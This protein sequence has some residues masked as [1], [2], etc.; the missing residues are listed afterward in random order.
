ME[1]SIKIL[2]V[3]FLLFASHGCKANVNVDNYFDDA[4][5][6]LKDNWEMEVNGEEAQLSS[7]PFRLHSRTNTCAKII[8]LLDR[9]D[10]RS[11]E[12]VLLQS[13]INRLFAANLKGLSCA[14][15]DND[16]FIKIKNLD[17][18]N[19]PNTLTLNALAYIGG[20][21]WFLNDDS[22]VVFEDEQSK[23]CFSEDLKPKLI[24]AEVVTLEDMQSALITEDTDFFRE[25]NSMEA[26]KFVYKC[27]LS[28]EKKYYLDV[29]YSKSYYENSK[30]KHLI[31]I[32]SIE[33]YLI[34]NK[35]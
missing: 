19:F 15:L 22:K 7:P 9:I 10:K 21:E 12:S 4:Y 25:E 23:Q 31:N 35:N 2:A 6:T 26:Y 8:V 17:G 28:N 3:V 27:K 29:Y 20:F 14:K 18:S 5:K 16:D 32:S 24:K 33:S 11:I 1:I 13:K 30:Y 34:D